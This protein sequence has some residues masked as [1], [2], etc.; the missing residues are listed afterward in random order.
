MKS[1]MLELSSTTWKSKIFT[2]N[3]NPVLMPL[4]LGKLGVRDIIE[5]YLPCAP[6]EE[7]QPINRK[8]FFID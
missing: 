5:P 4:N 6:K 7:I 8:G 3:F 2:G 1:T